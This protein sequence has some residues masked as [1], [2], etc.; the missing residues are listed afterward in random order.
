[1]LRIKAFENGAPV[2]SVDLASAYLVGNDRVPLRAD[3]RFA[4]G[5]I[6][7]DT[8]SRGAAALSILWP[9]PGVGRLMLETPRLQERRQ[10]YILNLEI[11]RGQLMR[12]AQKREDWGLYDFPEGQA[13]Y[14]Q[15]DAARKLLVEALTAADDVAASKFADQALIIAMKAGEAITSL[16]AE[17]FLKR[18][19]TS[20]QL[21]KRPLGCRIDAS[22]S[23]EGYLKAFGDLFDFA[24][25][26]FPWCSLE[27]QEGAFKP[28]SAD[29]VIKT[30]SQR[31]LQQWGMSLLS[32]DPVQL[33][34]WIQ[35]IGKDYERFR[36]CYTKHLRQVLKTYGS[37]IHVWEVIN[38]A[39]A[40]NTLGFTFEQIMDLTRI[41][42]LLVKQMS[43]KCQAVVGIVLP[44][45][46]YYARDAR[47]IP[48]TLYAE[49]AVQS[50]INFDAFGVEIRFGTGEPGG[51]ARDLLQISA[52]LDRFGAFGKPLHVTL[53]GVPSSGGAPADG[54]WRG[55][56]SPALQGEWMREVFRIALSKPFIE[57]V[58]SARFA[59]ATESC[60]LLDANG[61]PKPAFEEILRLRRE[62]SDA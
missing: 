12:I 46:E 13:I 52:M 53:T 3:I 1:M 37:F 6:V 42:A 26:S 45:G 44:W 32:L 15:I 59:D 4:A 60:G 48:P 14:D 47:T 33:P 62:I 22:Q 51:A 41:S 31:R 16:H 28:S 50:G 43:P 39:H 38:G 35:K 56:W 34:P 2:K 11:A 17:V 7:F 5:E 23:T 18:R 10:P 27:P 57:T 58:S 29:A 40:Y 9:V 20:G 54:E 8:R 36:D 61:R 49:M 24:I 21:A 19:I 25:H 55:P 30:I